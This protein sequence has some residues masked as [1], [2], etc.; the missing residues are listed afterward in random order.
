MAR[1]QRT[2]ELLAAAGLV[3]LDIERER[4]KGLRSA[5]SSQALASLLPSL[6]KTGAG[7]ADDVAEY[8][9][10]KQAV[11]AD[12]EI[13]LADAKAKEAD[14]LDRIASR[15]AKS[16]ADIAKAEAEKA[17]AQ[18]ETMDKQREASMSALRSAARAPG[19]TTEM[20]IGR[21]M[22]DEGLGELD[23]AGV[24]GILAEE[25]SKAKIEAKRAAAPAPK[26]GP[27]AEAIERQRLKDENLRLTNEALKR[28]PGEKAA[29]DKAKVEADNKKV[30]DKKRQQVI[31]I[32]SFARDIKR[33][34]DLVKAGID[35]TGTF[36]L[37]GPEGAIMSRRLNDIATLLAKLKDPGSVAKET[38][39]K[40]EAAG[41]VDVGL[42]GLLTRNSTA[43]QVL[44]ALIGDIE[45]RR[46]SAY[47]VRGLSPDDA[48]DRGPDL[49]AEAD[50]LGIELEP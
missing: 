4:Q 37:T 48:E 23:D 33:N 44:D 34:I 5:A 14:A 19:A 42:K 20:L 45:D 26:P 41:L 43:Q 32:E 2:A 27:S 7:I 3:D 50:E 31:E 11:G 36:E 1:A 21:A 46:R 39:V 38:E 47:E 8:D 17:K 13:G 24:A 9:L 35:K 16:A 30:A 29:D 40:A 25:Q 6:I 49:T 22:A 10:K 12:R 28:K 15:K 18:R